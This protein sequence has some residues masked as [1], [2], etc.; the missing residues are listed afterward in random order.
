MKKKILPFNWHLELGDIS[1]LDA[2]D[3]DFILLDNPIITSSF[4]YPLKVDFT[5]GIICIKG[6]M[7]GSVNLQQYSTQAPCLF[8][9]MAN[10]ILQY[11]SFSDDF[12]GRFI[13]MSKKF[14]ESLFNNMQETFPAFLSV[15]ESPWI[16]LNE[17]ALASMM[18][19]YGMI[20]SA[21]RKKDNPYRLEIAKLLTRAFFYGAGYY[22][23]QLNEKEKT[24][25]EL[26]VDDFLKLVQS[27]YK[28]QRAVDF[29]AD[30]L[31]L[32]PKYLSK[33][34][35]ENSGKSASD[36][37]EEYVLM[38]AKSLLKSTKMTVQQISDEL[39]FPSQSFF[40]KYFKR[41]SGFSPKEYRNN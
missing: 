15:R 32:T 29:Y 19:Y 27:N 38:E 5:I 21:V 41:H 14:I 1:Q 8:I 31:C 4:D 34:I 7:K 30:K 2:I 24:K 25:R 10:Q 11:E 12:S 39:N 35:K 3:E 17:E 22:F 28:N 37:I 23:H 9:L 16:P 33:V 6:T 13:I 26:L 20:Q 36:W 40:G 18:N